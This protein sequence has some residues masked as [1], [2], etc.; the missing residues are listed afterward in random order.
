MTSG[1]VTFKS[2]KK[3]GNEIVL[4]DATPARRLEEASGAEFACAVRA[5]GGGAPPANPLST[6]FFKVGHVFPRGTIR[7]VV[8]IPEREFEQI[9]ASQT[10]ARFEP[11]KAFDHA[12]RQALGLS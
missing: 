10:V 2:D 12:A 7:C 5:G 1:Y 9:K 4:R 11:R 3:H 8:V 6:V